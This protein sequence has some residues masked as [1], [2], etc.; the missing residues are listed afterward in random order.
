MNAPL[1]RLIFERLSRSPE[2]RD[3]PALVNDRKIS[4]FEMLPT[5]TLASWVLG[6]VLHGRFDV[7]APFLKT[8][9]R[10]AGYKKEIAARQ[11]LLDA[12]RAMLDAAP[13]REAA[14]RR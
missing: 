1:P 6:A 12:A 7:V 3:R 4:P 11:A 5:K 9:K 2:L 14:T 10:M 13:R 8:G